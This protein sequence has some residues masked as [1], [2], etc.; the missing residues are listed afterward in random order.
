MEGKIILKKMLP[1]LLKS[2]P[3][4]VVK[5][6]TEHPGFKLF[7]EKEVYQAVQ[8]ISL[9]HLPMNIY[10]R[11]Q[12]VLPNFGY[13]HKFLPSH[14]RIFAQQKKLFPYKTKDTF[15]TEKIYFNSTGELSQFITVISGNDLIQY[16]SSIVE[17]LEKQKK[18]QFENFDDSLWLLFSGGKGGKHMK[19]HFEVINCRNAGSVY[20]VHI[21]AIYGGSDSHSNMALVLPKCFEAIERLQSEE[22]SF[23]GHKV[24]IFL[25]GDYHFLDDCLGHQRSAATCPSSKDLVTLEHL[26]SHSGTAHTPEDCLIPERTIEDLE[27]SYNE[28]L[29]EGDSGLHK[30][31]KFYESIISRSLFPIKSL[32][33]VVPRILHI[34]F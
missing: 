12:R 5:K 33:H 18:L 14:H 29:V 15:A 32:S 10:Q 2:F 4:T 23:I 25:G 11:M 13:S 21:F 31:G 20:N 28:N 17:D 1:L 6:S 7:R 3:S 9:L 27:D 26:R 19:F 34:K 8:L 30:R 24:K 22:F 16:I